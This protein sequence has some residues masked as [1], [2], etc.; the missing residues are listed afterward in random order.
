MK[1]TPVSNNVFLLQE[2]GEAKIA[3]LDIPDS[4][5]KKVC[6]GKVVAVGPGWTTSTTGILQPMTVKVGDMVVYQE[7][8][9]TTVDF[10]GTDYLCVKE[11]DLLTIYES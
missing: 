4:E 11:T 3:G 6:K 7:H 9:A 5:R 1:I 8:S 2:E 10:Y